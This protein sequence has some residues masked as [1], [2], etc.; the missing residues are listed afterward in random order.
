MY[1]LFNV[2]D[3]CQTLFSLSFFWVR[4]HPF[5][6][7]I[8][9]FENVRYT[10]IKSINKCKFHDEFATITIRFGDSYWML[11]TFDFAPQL[12]VFTHFCKFRLRIKLHRYWFYFQIARKCWALTNLNCI[13]R[14]LHFSRNQKINA[15]FK[16]QNILTKSFTKA[17]A[18]RWKP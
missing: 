8:I 15:M 4:N 11:Q 6:I 17:L 14:I 3:K 12:M 13:G 18:D 16:L 10:R 9:L 1:F 2:I 7:L 5:S